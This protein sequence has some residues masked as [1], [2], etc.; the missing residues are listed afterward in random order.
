MHTDS[1]VCN[2]L[3]ITLII[4]TI[5]SIRLTGCM[6]G[7]CIYRQ[8]LCK[9]HIEKFR[10]FLRNREKRRRWSLENVPHATPSRIHNTFPTSQHYHRT[11][12]ITFAVAVFAAL[13]SGHT[14]FTIIWEC[15]CSHNC[16]PFYWSL[17]LT[18]SAKTSFYCVP[19]LPVSFAVNV[20]CVT[21]SEWCLFGASSTGLWIYPEKPL[22]LFSL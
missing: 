7:C 11:G 8:E 10:Y 15:R 3:L 18:L 14:C 6:C 2:W 4:A 20:K 16:V 9:L 17:P 22:L 19:Q 12:C 13:L 5:R 21:W 1:L